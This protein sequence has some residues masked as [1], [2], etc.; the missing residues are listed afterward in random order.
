MIQETIL[1]AAQSI[2][3]PAD[4]DPALQALVAVV[5]VLYLISTLLRKFVDH[6]LPDKTA[7]AQLKA[8]ETMVA[9]LQATATSIESGLRRNEDKIDT[10]AADVRTI[11]SGMDK[12]LAGI[13]DF[14]RSFMPFARMDQ[15]GTPRWWCKFPDCKDAILAK[16]D[17]FEGK[18]LAALKS[19]AT[20]KQRE[21]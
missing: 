21:N 7:K 9:Q 5:G 13:D 8:T 19:R 14:Q 10:V 11:G 20:E 16:I 1:M 18:T 3:L 17:D 12:T 4:S 2:N 15:S 6:M